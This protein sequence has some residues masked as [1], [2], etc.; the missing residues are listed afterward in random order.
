MTYEGRDGNFI[1]EILT[2][3]SCKSVMVGKEEPGNEWLSLWQID[4]FMTLPRLF[5]GEYTGP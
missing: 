4:Y 3:V 1:R 5:P 2:S